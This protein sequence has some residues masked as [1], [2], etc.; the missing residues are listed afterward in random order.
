MLP[1]SD[2]ASWFEPL[3]P[4]DAAAIALLLAACMPDAWDEGMVAEC[5]AAG[6]FGFVMRGESEEAGSAAGL[7]ACGILRV[8]GHEGE[9]LQ[10]AVAGPSRRRGIGGGMLRRLLGECARRAVEVVFLE[11]RAGN[12][13]ARELY[14]RAGFMEVGMRERY[15]RDGEQAVV[16]AVTLSFPLPPG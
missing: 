12:Q 10:L 5:L 2:S 6:S 15:Y 4:D 7:V 14:S 13:A 3:I 1:P 11:V 16:M 9:I 8:V